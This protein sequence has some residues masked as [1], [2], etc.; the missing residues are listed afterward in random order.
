MSSGHKEEEKRI[1]N[2]INQEVTTT[3]SEDTI[4]LTIYYKNTK[5][6][7][8]IM[9]NAPRREDSLLKQHHV[10]YK[11]RC[12][13]AG[14]PATYVG[15]TTMKLSKR[16][17][18]HLQEGAIFQH[19]RE[20]HH[21]RPTRENIIENVEILAKAPDQQRLKYMEALYILSDNPS[22]NTTN[23]INFLP[24]LLQRIKIGN[25]PA[26]IPQEPSPTTQQ[27]S[28]NQ[29]NPPSTENRAHLRP[30]T[31]QNSAPIPPRSPIM[32]RSR[33]HRT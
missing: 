13:Y 6:S 27:I 7:N 1:K 32:T 21:A 2:I 26:S 11:Y 8:L 17:S 14:C 33:C 23:E 19:H 24:S 12:H 25:N 15:M 4:A 5:T 28:G 9:T 20:H 31:N 29:G 16:L 18:V 10:I 22:L 30:G 3:K